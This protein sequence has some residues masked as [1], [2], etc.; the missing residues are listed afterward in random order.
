MRF[1]WILLILVA[2]SLVRP[3]LWA[4]APLPNAGGG[5]NLV[6]LEGEGAINNVKQRTSRET[7]VQVEDGNHK[8]VAG[9]VVVFLLPDDGP[10]GTFVSGSRTATVVTGSNGQAV[11]PGLQPNQLTGPY[12]VRVNALFGG[13][14]ASTTINQS[15][16]AAAA[17]GWLIGR[18]P[19]RDF[20]EGYR[21]HYRGGGGRGGG[22]GAGAEQQQQEYAG[23]DTGTAGDAHR[24]ISWAAARCLDR[25]TRPA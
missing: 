11:M 23:G 12:Q 2:C 13:R 9:A 14:Q 20:R 18:G 22:S 5:L 19:C 1:R 16:V 8:P 7:I 3:A 21:H 17:A 15:N 4:Q 10:S 6:I 24:S 25:R